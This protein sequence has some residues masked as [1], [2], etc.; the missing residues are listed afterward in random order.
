M[1]Q[2]SKKFLTGVFSAAMAGV[3]LLTGCTSEKPKEEAKATDQTMPEFKPMD[4]TGKKIVAEYKNGKVTEGELNTY[5]NFYSFIDPQLAMAFSN[6]EMSEQLN[7]FKEQIAQ[8]YAAQKYISIKQKVDDSIKKESDKMYNELEKQILTAPSE[9]EEEKPKTLEEAIKGKGFTK[10][11]MQSYILRNIQ[12]NQYLNSQIKGQTYDYIKAQ[13]I[14]VGIG[15]GEQGSPKRTDA[16]AKKR[17]D[18]VKKKL[19][20]GGD[21][22]ALAK[23]YSDDPG[24]KETGGYIE[25][26]ASMFVPEFSKAAQTQPLNKAT[27]PVK[28]NYGYHVIKPLERKEESLDKADEQ[29]KAKPIQEAYNEIITKE[30]AFK[31]LLPKSEPA[32]K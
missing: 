22:K 32:D 23:E 14:L 3:L 5:I 11:D 25:G 10:N 19:D 16:E 21:F 13:H 20:E 18:E 17:A 24:S 15:D 9:E 28:T 31:S 8:D 7:Q 4:T 2:R 6:P 12:V 26:D 30:L 1:Q 27:A 29:V